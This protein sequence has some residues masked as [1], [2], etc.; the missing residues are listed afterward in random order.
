MLRDIRTSTY[1]I[2]RTEKKINRTTTFNKLIYKLTPGV[3]ETCCLI[4]NQ[5]P[6]FHIEISDYSW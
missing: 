6:D 5:G 2:C 1:Q 4:F 3:R